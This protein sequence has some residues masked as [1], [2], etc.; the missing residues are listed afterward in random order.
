MTDSETISCE[1]VAVTLKAL[2]AYRGKRAWEE[3]SSESDSEMMETLASSSQAFLDLD[4]NSCQHC[5][6]FFVRGD[7]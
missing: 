4:V 7:F 5:V 2:L 3:Y 1:R 6:F